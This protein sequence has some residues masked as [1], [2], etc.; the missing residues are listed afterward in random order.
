MA[1]DVCK[2]CHSQI[3]KEG[4]HYQVTDCVRDELRRLYDENA[5]LKQMIDEGLGWEDMQRD[6][7]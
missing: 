4:F 2:K 7:N 6:I 1:I 5:K 3:D